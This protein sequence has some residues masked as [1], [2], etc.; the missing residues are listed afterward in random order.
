MT[1]ETQPA[2]AAVRAI[3]VPDIRLHFIDEWELRGSFYK[4]TADRIVRMGW[5]ESTGHANAIM[6]HDSIKKA[7]MFWVS[8]AFMPLLLN[9]ADSLPLDAKFSE[10][11]PLPPDGL[12]IFD[13]PKGWSFEEEGAP[14]AEVAAISWHTGGV[15]HKD[16]TRFNEAV[17]A[18]GY[19]R[20]GNTWVDLRSSSWGGDD[21]IAVLRDNSVLEDEGSINRIQRDRKILG[22]FAHLIRETTITDS[23]NERMPRPVERR[24]HRQS[25]MSSVRI[26]RLRHLAESERNGT[27]LSASSV[28]Y[29]HQWL[30]SGHWRNQPCGTGRSE[31]KLIWISPHVKGPADKPLVLKDT[32]KALVR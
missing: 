19:A 7:E 12:L 18:D 17:F 24:S 32:V 20:Y 30:V 28:D 23:Q 13:A 26:V 15:K 2:K 3:E 14:K 16:G 8:P 22:A 5:P 25:V 11:P 27:G 31:R 29:S 9:A 4:S 10:L 1:D 21:A 6:M